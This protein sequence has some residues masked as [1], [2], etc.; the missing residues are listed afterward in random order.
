MIKAII[1]DAGEVIYYRDEETL[2]PILDFLKRKGFN[3]S[4]K[5][6]IKAYDEHILKTY[7][8]KI[9][10]DEHL[11]KTLEF[12]KIRFDDRF[13]NGFARVF[14]KNFSNIKIKESMSNIFKKIKSLGIKICILTDT[15]TTEESKWKWFRKIN[16]AQFIDIIVCSS[17]TRHTKDEKKSY[18]IALKKLNIKPNEAIFVGHKKYEMKGAK[19]AG[20]KSVSIEKDAGGDYYIKD[21]SKILRIIKNL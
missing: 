4:A 11:K 16:I 20:I 10:K 7:K 1:F 5:Y 9:S 8:G 15:L 21:I 14:R 12:L 18:I 6:F 19:L 13:F 3:I 2:K 17:T